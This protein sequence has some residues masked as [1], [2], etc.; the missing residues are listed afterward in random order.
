M[1]NLMPMPD[2]GPLV[3]GVVA[4][5]IL[6][7]AAHI[8]LGHRCRLPAGT[9]MPHM[10]GDQETDPAMR[11]GLFAMVGGMA[12]ATA[13]QIITMIPLPNMLTGPILGAVTTLGLMLMNL[14]APYLWKPFMRQRRMPRALIVAGIAHVALAILIGFGKM[15]TPVWVQPFWY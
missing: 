9:E 13:M 2:I 6:Y 11:V 12:Y 3:P 4:A 8:L 10:V 7:C 14:A 5:I 1:T 15:L